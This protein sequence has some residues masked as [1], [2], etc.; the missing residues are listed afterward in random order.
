[1]ALATCCASAPPA[2]T[3]QPPSAASCQRSLHCTSCIIHAHL[4]STPCCAS[5]DGVV[6]PDVAPH[7]TSSKRTLC[8]LSFEDELHVEIDSNTTSVR[9]Q[10]SAQH[11]FAVERNDVNATPAINPSLGTLGTVVFGVAAARGARPYMEDRHCCVPSFVPMSSNGT[12]MEDAIQRCVC[13]V[14]TCNV[15]IGATHQCV[16]HFQELCSGV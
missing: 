14:E 8:R 9:M 5:R 11:C 10:S 15:C 6:T 7:V 1:M 2:L 16:H 13:Q 4:F 12:P 3:P